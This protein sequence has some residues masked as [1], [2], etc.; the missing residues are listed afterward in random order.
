MQVSL[1]LIKLMVLS[2][3]ALYYHRDIH[4]GDRQH[5]LAQICYEYIDSLQK[6]RDSQNMAFK[7][8]S[9]GHGGS[10]L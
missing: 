9:A 7:D 1:Q 4:P 2:D 6:L 3:T 10:R 8:V 5:L